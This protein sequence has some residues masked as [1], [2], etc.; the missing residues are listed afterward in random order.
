MKLKLLKLQGQFSVPRTNFYIEAF[1]NF[2]TQRVASYDTDK[3]QGLIIL[4]EGKNWV[5]LKQ[6][7]K[8]KEAKLHWGTFLTTLT[9]KILFSYYILFK[10]FSKINI[11]SPLTGQLPV[12][13]I[14]F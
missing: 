13:T 14:D 8:V 5:K 2:T 9:I 4:L 11:Y 6:K 10:F 12:L 1:F 3:M 7:L